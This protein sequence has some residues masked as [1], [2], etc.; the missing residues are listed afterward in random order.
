MESKGDTK[1]EVSLVFVNSHTLDSDFVMLGA[2]KYLIVGNDVADRLAGEAAKRVA[3]PGSALALIDWVDATAACIRRRLVEATMATIAADPSTANGRRVVP[4]PRQI[5][6]AERRQ[7]MAASS[8]AWLKEGKFWRCQGCQAKANSRTIRTMAAT[9]CVEM[10]RVPV[11][12]NTRAHASHRCMWSDQLQLWAC[13]KC[14]SFA[15]S[16]IRKLALPCSLVLNR[17]GKQNLARLERGIAP[18]R[19]RGE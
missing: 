2:P 17:R 3:L 5:A 15:K 18:Q 4:A 13:M 8:H 10:P 12:G 16:R 6:K 1:R 14:G 19:N 7:W 11:F 9:R